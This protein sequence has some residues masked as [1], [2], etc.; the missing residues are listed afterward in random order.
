MPIMISRR[1]LE[2]GDFA[3]WKE[4]FE[5]GAPARKEAGCRG[6][7]RFVNI[8][9]PEEVVILFDWNSHENARK[10]VETKLAANSKLLE[11]R[12]AGIPKLE[13]IYLEE[14]A[15]LPS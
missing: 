8:N 5:A 13:N 6:V 11:E 2:P 12:S 10:F 3:T 14:L 7:R 9:D 4:R 15:P 1:K